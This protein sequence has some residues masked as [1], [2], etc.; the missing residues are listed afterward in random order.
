MNRDGDLRCAGQAQRVAHRVGKGVGQRVAAGAQCLYGGVAIVD[1]I[2]VRTIGC[3]IDGTVRS[4]DIG[5]HVG[6]RAADHTRRDTGNR[7]RITGIRVGVVGQDVAGGVGAG[8]S[9]ISTTRFDRCCCIGN[10]R[11]RGVD[12]IRDLEVIDE[13]IKGTASG[14][15]DIES[16]SSSAGDVRGYVVG[17]AACRRIQGLRKGIQ[18][19]PVDSIA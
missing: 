15:A 9:I 6:R 12:V 8:R 11:R 14:R 1:G 3:D 7:F 18:R 19:N 16:D 2:R 4:R 17:L 10:S 13:E 5:T